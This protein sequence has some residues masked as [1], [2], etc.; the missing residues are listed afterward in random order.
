[1]FWKIIS[2]VK[3][4]STSRYSTSAVL[5]QN[6]YC[7]RQFELQTDGGMFGINIGIPVPSVYFPFSRNNDSF[8]GDQ[9]VL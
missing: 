7:A 1:M 3:C 6:G 4:L 8:F 5:V 2:I 9:H